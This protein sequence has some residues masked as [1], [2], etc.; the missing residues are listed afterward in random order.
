[1]MNK[2]DAALN[3]HQTALRVRNQRQ[4]LLASNIANADTPQY[5][6][7][8][9]DFKS[10][11]QAALNPSTTSTGSSGSV[12][13]SSNGGMQQT[14]PSHLSGQGSSGYLSAGDPL[15]RSVVQGSVDGNTVDMDVERNAYVDN[16]IRYEAS[17]TMITGQI[18]KMLS[19]INGQ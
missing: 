1:M 8:D 3:F 9:L 2:L 16:G 7:R 11:M 15:F 5:K 18:K 14:N 6:A 19:A 12:G 13:T 4:E 17:L 10:A